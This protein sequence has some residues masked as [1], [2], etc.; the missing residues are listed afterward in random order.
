M[1]SPTLNALVRKP[2]L[3]CNSIAFQDHPEALFDHG[4][5]RCASLGG[6][7]FSPDGKVIGNVDRCLH[8]VGTRN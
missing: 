1:Q 7:F 3:R 5:K 4:T 2:I 8:D 6:K